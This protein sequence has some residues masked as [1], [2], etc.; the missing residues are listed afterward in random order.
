M[1]HGIKFWD[2]PKI[3]SDQRDNAFEV[4]L[5]KYNIPSMVTCGASVDKVLIKG[6]FGNSKDTFTC[7]GY[8][9]DIEELITSFVNDERNYKRLEAARND[10]DPNI[11]QNTMVPQYTPVALKYLFGIRSVFSWGLDKKL[12]IDHLKRGNGIKLCL[13]AG[14]FI[15]IVAYDDELEE[16]IYYDSWTNRKFLENDGIME[17]FPAYRLEKDFDPYHVVICKD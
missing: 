13:K 6:I 5:K 3:H 15:A 1:I 16:F 8:E 4:V 14:H 11:Y 17:R 10:L 9:L 12:L 2:N 7:E